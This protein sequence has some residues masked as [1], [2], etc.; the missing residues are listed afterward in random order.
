LHRL[1]QLRIASGHGLPHPKS[2]IIC[3]IE[4]DTQ[5]TE[6]AERQYLV[7]VKVKIQKFDGGRARWEQHHLFSNGKFLTLESPAIHL[8]STA[9]T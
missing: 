7:K 8:N 9:G 4:K 3:K 5:G 1:K 2:E 6:E